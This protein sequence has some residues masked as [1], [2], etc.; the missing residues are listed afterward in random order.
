CVSKAVY[1]YTFHTNFTS[2]GSIPALG[3]VIRT[4]NLLPKPVENIKFVPGNIYKYTY[5]Y[6]YFVFAKGT[7]SI[8][9]VYPW[10]LVCS[11]NIRNTGVDKTIRIP[12][13][14]GL[15]IIRKYSFA[16]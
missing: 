7:K 16:L 13:F 10:V 8:G 14:N 11:C 6:K 4:K 3:I 9:N 12:C 5:R 2:V 15:Y 1:K